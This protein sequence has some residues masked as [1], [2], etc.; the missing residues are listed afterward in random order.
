MP[1]RGEPDPGEAAGEEAGAYCF[2][3]DVRVKQNRYELSSLDSG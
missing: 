3:V 2:Q 1:E